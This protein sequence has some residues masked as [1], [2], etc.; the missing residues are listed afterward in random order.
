MVNYLEIDLKETGQR[1]RDIRQQHNYTMDE[2]GELLDNASKGTVNHWERGDNLPNKSRLEK[3]ALLGKITTD[4]LLYGSYEQYVIRLIHQFLDNE[5]ALDYDHMFST[6]LVASL[7]DWTKISGTNSVHS[8][9]FQDVIQETV[10]ASHDKGLSF[11]DD[12]QILR[13][14]QDVLRRYFH[15]EGYTNSGLITYTVNNLKNF[16][17]EKLSDYRYYPNTIFEREGISE[18]L[19]KEIDAIIDKSAQQ[20]NELHK[21]FDE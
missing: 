12:A 3:I 4:E 15:N 18:Q 5:E 13:V 14:F 11:G 9:K 16:M 7:D 10:R 8:K 2:F 19:F 1:I 6:A 17:S 21:R 20:I